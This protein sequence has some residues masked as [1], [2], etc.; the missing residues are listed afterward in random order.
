MIIIMKILMIAS[1]S[2]TKRGGTGM[3]IVAELPVHPTI[4]EMK[5]VQPKDGMTRK[6]VVS[7]IAGMARPVIKNGNSLTR[8][9]L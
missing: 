2:A 3:E 4:L 6:P 1:I 7:I 5:V 9:T 8:A